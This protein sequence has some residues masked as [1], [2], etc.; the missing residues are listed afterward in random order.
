MEQL[1]PTPQPY[2]K[3]LH[4]LEQTLVTI[5]SYLSQGNFHNSSNDWLEDEAVNKT[6]IRDA[7]IDVTGDEGG[8]P[9]STMKEL[10]RVMMMGIKYIKRKIEIGRKMTCTTQ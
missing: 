4:L 3:S 7:V 10:S 5:L 8:S 1:Q 9:L 2:V 6:D